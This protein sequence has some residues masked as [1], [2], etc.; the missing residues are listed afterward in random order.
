MED[1][2]DNG[3]AWGDVAENWH[4][5]WEAEVEAEV[6]WRAKTQWKRRSADVRER[7][8]CANEPEVEVGEESVADG[9]NPIR[10]PWEVLTLARHGYPEDWSVFAVLWPMTLE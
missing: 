4:T 9:G 6:E 10:F 5:V 7:G 8:R 2:E 3:D 1:G